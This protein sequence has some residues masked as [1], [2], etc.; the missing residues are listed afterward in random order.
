MTEKKMRFSMDE[1]LQQ[2]QDQQKNIKYKQQDNKKFINELQ[3]IEQKKNCIFSRSLLTKYSPSFSTNNSVVA[4]S[5]KQNNNT[6][7]INNNINS[8]AIENND[9]SI[10]ELKIVHN[11]KNSLSFLKDKTSKTQF[12][13]QELESEQ[14]AT[15]SSR[16]NELN[17]NL[18]N[19]TIK[20]ININNNN[21]KLCSIVGKK[22]LAQL[23]CFSNNTLTEKHSNDT[24]LISNFFANFFQIARCPISNN[25]EIPNFFNNKD[26]AI[27]KT[28]SF[29]NHLRPVQSNFFDSNK[30]KK[31]Y[32]E[33]FK[34]KK[35]IE[36]EITTPNKQKQH[37]YNKRKFLNFNDDEE[38]EDSL[39][40]NCFDEDEYVDDNDSNK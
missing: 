35:I 22:R 39:E 17:I 4:T 36:T 14:K 24:A 15:T 3:K 6:Q 21:D 28:T 29:T 18:N 38:N 30:I 37:E 34:T 32:N 19:N 40:Q 2:Q 1:I 20:N 33:N 12:L 9:Q 16:Y 13:I 5:K 10:S 8:F 11:K 31:K 25:D 26:M 23:P 27:K 7:I